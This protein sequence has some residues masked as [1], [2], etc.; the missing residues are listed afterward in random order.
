MNRNVWACSLASGVLLLVGTLNAQQAPPPPGLGHAEGA[1]VG[2]PGGPFDE[3]IELLGFEGLHPGKV[4][5][6]APFRATAKSET[7]QTL[8]DG[9]TIDRTTS[10]AMYRDSD[11]RVRREVTLSGF[12]PLQTSGKPR[13][14]ITI[15]DSVT[16]KHYLLDPEK[17]VAY[18]MTPPS[19][20]KHGGANGNAQAFQQKMQQRMAKE[21]ASGEL[22]KDSPDTQTIN[23]N[24]V[25][26]KTEHTSITRTIP[27]GR[28]GN[29]KAI[30]IVVER[31]YSPDLQIVVKSTRTD[32]RF[33]TTTYALTSLQTTEPAAGMCTVPADYT[34]KEGGPGGF[35]KRMRGFRG[36]QPGGGPGDVPPP[37]PGV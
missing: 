26:V 22:K 20:G 24:G 36:G 27:M 25:S 6:G 9:T 31:W 2:G 34:M 37:P 3:R 14:L 8:Q 16:G 5:K 35:G 19:G 28:I 21:E 32:P 13:T 11:G 4:V 7:T 30:Q 33:G 12:G 23:I 18:V 10:S 29:N 17:K 15:N 1:D